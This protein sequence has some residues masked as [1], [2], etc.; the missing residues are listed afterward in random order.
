MGVAR[1]KR[2]S[3][4]AQKLRQRHAVEVRKVSCRSF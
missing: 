2:V 3:Q 1:A 4:N